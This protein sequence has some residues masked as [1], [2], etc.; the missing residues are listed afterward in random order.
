[1]VVF[2]FPGQGSQQPG[3][4]RPWRDHP[5]FELVEEASEVLERDMAWLL[6][7]ADADTL[8]ITRN[9]QVATLLMSVVA[10]DAIERLGVAPQ[11]IAGHSLGEYAA[12]V[13][14]GGISLEAGLLLVQERGDAMAQAAEQSPGAMIALLGANL[15]QALALV[16]AIGPDLWLANHN[17]EAQIVLSGTLDAVE[18]AEALAREYG[19]RRV[20]R[21]KVGGAFHSP[22]MLEAKDRLRKAIAQTRFY[23][24]EV[25]VIANVDA[26][27][28]TAA[29][30]WPSLLAE[31]LTSPVRWYDTMNAIRASRPQLI[32]EVGPG[33]V[34]TNLAKRHMPEIPAISVAEPDD[35]DELVELLAGDGPVADWAA[36]HQGERLYGSERLIVAPS[37]G[38]FTP[39]DPAPHLGDVVAVGTLIGYVGATAVRS[40]FAGVLREMLAVPGERVT[41]GQ[42]LAWLSEAPQRDSMLTRSGFA[43]VEE[44]R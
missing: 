44:G 28:H 43:A 35:L 3:M 22:Y 18:A 33:G 1:M 15:E 10:L 29:T 31:Q 7:D 2:L 19:I 42:P 21:L 4:G 12:L 11:L 17:S 16:D 13:A 30:E 36:S 26:R 24:L 40:A 8:Q 34:L 27:E 37:T 9:T 6:L 25:P 41:A 23:D 14:A 32:V 39:L 20:T 38:V 5:S